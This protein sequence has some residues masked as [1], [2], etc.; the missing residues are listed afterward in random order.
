MLKGDAVVATVMSN[1]GLQVG[2]EREGLRLIRSG[3]G[4]R[5]VV[6]AMREGGYNFGG[7]QSGH[8]LFLDHN[9]TGDGLITS[10]QTLAIMRRRGRT[11]SE[12]ASGF[13]RYPQV[14]VNVPVAKKRPIEELSDMTAA[15]KKVEAEL[16]REGRVLIR[17]SGT[18][19]KARVMVEGPD[20]ECVSNYAQ[21]LAETLQRSLGAS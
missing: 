16:G 11:L 14:L 21:D 5:Y 7:E 13:Q 19:R 3:V 12:L 10:L 2:L 6:E 1:L 4:D 8:I 17:Y 18:E 20:E 9:S 15:I